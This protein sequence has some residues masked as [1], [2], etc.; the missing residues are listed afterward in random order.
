MISGIGYREMKV[1]ILALI[2]TFFNANA[3]LSM[4]SVK[5]WFGELWDKGTDKLRSEIDDLKETNMGQS[6]SSV[7]SKA[8]NLV[9][10]NKSGIITSDV[11]KAHKK[12]LDLSIELEEGIK[13]GIETF[14]ALKSDKYK[15][16]IELYEKVLPELRSLKKHLSKELNTLVNGKVMIRFTEKNVNNIVEILEEDQGMLSL[17]LELKGSFNEFKD[18]LEKLEKEIKTEK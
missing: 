1:L 2:T 8:E 5:G 16:Q 17:S 4:E 7:F 13:T 15:D 18:A 9:Q 11:L 10:N 14:S 6:V 12:F 3:A